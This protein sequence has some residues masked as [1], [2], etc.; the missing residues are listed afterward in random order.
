MPQRRRFPFERPGAAALGLLL[1][2]A[3]CT[4]DPAEP[5]GTGPVRVE[6][7]AAATAFVP[8]GQEVP[9]TATVTSDRGRGIPNFHLNFNVLYFTQTVTTLSR[10]AFVRASEIMSIRPD[11]SDEVR[12]TENTN[13]DFH[14]SWSPDGSRIAFVRNW[15]IWVMNADGTGQAKL[16]AKIGSLDSE[17]A[18]SPDGRRLSFRSTHEGN[19][20]IYVMDADGND[21]TRITSWPGYD[22]NATWSPRREQ[23]CLHAP[24]GQP[25][26]DHGRERGRLARATAHQQH[27]LRR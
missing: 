5:G 16:L 23:N 18:W 6:V 24:R 25:V 15:E 20:E 19:D 3:G 8:C 2:A 9:V 7:V 11:G 21:P 1:C 13:P 12:H 27:R 17:P 26:R 22:Q 10:I 14:P 4:D